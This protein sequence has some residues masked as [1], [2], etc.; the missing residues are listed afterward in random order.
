MNSHLKKKDLEKATVRLQNE[1]QK[2]S[3]SN[4]KELLFFLSKVCKYLHDKML[5]IQ[6]KE[7]RTKIMSG[8]ET[9]IYSSKRVRGFPEL[10]KL[11]TQFKNHYGSRFVR[12]AINNANGRVD[13]WVVSRLNELSPRKNEIRRMQQDPKVEMEK[14]VTGI[15]IEEG[16]EN[17]NVTDDNDWENLPI[18]F[19]KTSL[20][21]SIYDNLETE[22]DQSIEK[23]SISMVA[24]TLPIHIFNPNPNLEIA[25]NTQTK[26]PVYVL[27]KIDGEI[28]SS[29]SQQRPS[30]YEDKNLPLVFRSKLS[31]YHHSGYDRGHMAPAADFDE[32][33][34]HDTFN[35]CNVSPQLH[36][37]NIS[38]WKKLENWC[39]AVAKTEK[40]N[41]Q[42]VTYVVTGPLWLPQNK[43]S[44]KQFTYSF[45]G[46]GASD[47][48]SLVQ[49]PTDFFKVVVVVSRKTICKVACFVVPNA[50]IDEEKRK[51]LRHFVV[52]WTDLECM[53]G[54]QF[55]PALT[56]DEGWKQKVNQLAENFMMTRDNTPVMER[57]ILAPVGI[58]TDVQPIRGSLQ[59][60]IVT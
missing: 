11:R 42:G 55:F 23:S 3:T 15:D 45:H 17:S 56:G 27:E 32:K 16:K 58:K 39:R 10:S 30:F 21:F 31:H 49:V 60:L 43:T 35:L 54:L 13:K 53:S 9:L 44:G 14:A 36:S 26:N 8:V 4:D 2:A 1:G 51:S 28:Q 47:G 19:G 24:P 34:V 41:I 46:I 57:E 29:E 7:P 22:K 52:Q 37:M 20:S 50:N 12:N 59:H 33:E 48:K 38:V 5:L 6:N 25:F 18:Q 40:E